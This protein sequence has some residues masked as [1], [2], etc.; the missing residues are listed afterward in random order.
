MRG[1][2]FA[3]GLGRNIRYRTE[4]LRIRF[5]IACMRSLLENELSVVGR[6]HRRRTDYDAKDQTESYV[7]ES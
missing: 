6:V 7:A 1:D 2:R 5:V 4:L 3:C